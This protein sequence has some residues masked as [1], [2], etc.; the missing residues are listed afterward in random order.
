MFWFWLRRL[1]FNSTRLDSTRFI[2]AFVSEYVA[3][4]NESNFNQ[5]T[6][7]FSD[8]NQTLP[9]SIDLILGCSIGEQE[10]R[11][12]IEVEWRIREFK[13]ELYANESVLA[14]TKRS[15]SVSESAQERLWICRNHA[16]CR[17]CVGFEA[18][19][20]NKQQRTTSHLYEEGYL[21]MEENH[22]NKH[23]WQQWS[24]MDLEIEWEWERETSLMDFL[25]ILLYSLCSACCLAAN[26][27]PSPRSIRFTWIVKF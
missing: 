24:A 10:M 12:T 11:E 4:P 20:T 6:R 19:G 15:Q 23:R 27:N 5:T 2:L 22:I 25:F 21:G 7:R 1:R 3:H 17:R 16:A 18:W 14:D 26:F 13:L 9:I 8:L